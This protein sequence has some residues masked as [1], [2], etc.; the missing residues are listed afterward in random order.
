MEEKTNF[1]HSIICENRKSLHLSGVKDVVSFD[2]ETLL[3]E[4][5]MG[6]MTVKGENLHIQNFANETGDLTADGRVH[7]LVYLSDAK[8]GGFF[9]KLFR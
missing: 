8:S 5:V 6:R 4:T 9:S 1:S 2:E 3:L 7:A